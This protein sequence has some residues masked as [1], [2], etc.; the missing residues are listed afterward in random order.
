MLDNDK[1]CVDHRLYC[2]VRVVG[3]AA[4][5]VAVEAAPNRCGGWPD[6]HPDREFAYFGVLGAVA[7]VVGMIVWAFAPQVSRLMEGVH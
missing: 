7:I 4:I 1:C 3:S 6:C 2:S 5:G